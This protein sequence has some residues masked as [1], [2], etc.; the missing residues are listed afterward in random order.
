MRARVAA[1]CRPRAVGCLDE[2][3][4][5]EL[6]LIQGHGG[7]QGVAALF[8]ALLRFPARTGL[9]PSTTPEEEVVAA[10]CMNGLRPTSTQK[11]TC[12]SG[13]AVALVPLAPGK[14]VR[15][16]ATVGH[17]ARFP[18]ATLDLYAAADATSPLW[19]H[20]V[21]VSAPAADARPAPNSQQ[22]TRRI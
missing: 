4:L 9:T 21:A 19:M 8:A 13:L 6:K 17:H 16:E 22:N 11:A 14:V 12:R 18:S 10:D 3:I 20:V 7:R 15:I 5:I 2:L 1:F